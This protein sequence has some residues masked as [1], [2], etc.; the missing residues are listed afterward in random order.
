MNARN[1]SLNLNVRGLAPSATLAIN[2][3]CNELMREG[4]RVFK[5]GLG[6]YS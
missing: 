4:K 3:R 5:L 6:A 1:I 2:A